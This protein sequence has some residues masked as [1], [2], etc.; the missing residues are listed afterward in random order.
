MKKSTVSISILLIV[1]VTITACQSSV[2]QETYN[3]DL[4]MAETQVQELK[5]DIA[6]LRQEL[7]NIDK[8]ISSLRGAVP[9]LAATD[10]LGQWNSIIPSSVR[11]GVRGL[12]LGEVFYSDPDPGASEQLN[13]AFLR[14][15]LISARDMVASDIRYA[16][17]DEQY[18]ILNQCLEYIMG[19][20]S[21]TRA[22]GFE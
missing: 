6:D 5:A 21:V 3:Q 13:K 8:E 20:N 17:P 14:L 1:V 12:N 16:E 11:S 7:F 18:R 2:P 19:I 4:A 15:A 22:C 9:E 10:I